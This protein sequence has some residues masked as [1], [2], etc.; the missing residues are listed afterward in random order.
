MK[1]YSV[2]L[3]K[4]GAYE[5]VIASNPTSALAKVWDNNKGD[6]WLRKYKNKIE[7]VKSSYV[8]EMLYDENGYRKNYKLV[9]SPNKN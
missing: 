2:Q 4:A 8:Y 3:L 1:S 9:K 6:S 5:P 7:F